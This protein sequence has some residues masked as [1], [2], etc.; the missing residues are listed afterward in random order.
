MVVKRLLLEELESLEYKNEIWQKIAEL[1]EVAELYKKATSPMLQQHDLIKTTTFL[2]SSNG[3]SVDASDK[4][5]QRSQRR[6]N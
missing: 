5:L 1:L 6:E 2:C 3:A 4:Q